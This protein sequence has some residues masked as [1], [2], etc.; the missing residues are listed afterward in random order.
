MID[1]NIDNINQPYYTEPVENKQSILPDNIK[2]MEKTGFYQNSE[3]FPPRGSFINVPAELL[4]GPNA[5]LLDLVF[6]D[7]DNNIS[8]D[9]YNRTNDIK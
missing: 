1:K 4:F 7:K 5:K 8:S 3:A 6:D 9:L 2:N